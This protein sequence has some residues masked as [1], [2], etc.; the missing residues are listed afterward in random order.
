MHLWQYRH[1]YHQLIF[2]VG[3]G[4][5]LKPCKQVPS[6]VIGP[7]EYMLQAVHMRIE[8]ETRGMCL[9]VRGANLEAV[10]LCI[11]MIHCFHIYGL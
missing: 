8:D 5:L 6:I 3:G 1:T 7:E 9:E 10:E 11:Y 2:R 4:K